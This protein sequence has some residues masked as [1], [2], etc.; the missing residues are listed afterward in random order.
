M[1]VLVRVHTCC[2]RP[3]TAE[4]SLQRISQTTVTV[5]TQ[6]P[7]SDAS[8]IVVFKL[9]TIIGEHTQAGGSGGRRGAARAA[10]LRRK[11]CSTVSA[12]AGVWRAGLVVRTRTRIRPSSTQCSAIHGKIQLYTTCALS[13]R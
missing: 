8:D 11:L 13:K 1:E 4:K 3:A 7:V 5:V 6:V 10:Q 9:H 12:I 2:A